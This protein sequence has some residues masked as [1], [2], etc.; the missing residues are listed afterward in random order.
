MDHTGIKPT[1]LVLSALYH[2]S[3]MIHI[4]CSSMSVV[5]QLKASFELE[6]FSWIVFWWKEW[7]KISSSCRMEKG[8]LSQDLKTPPMLDAIPWTS[9]KWVLVGFAFLVSQRGG[10]S[11]LIQC[12]MQEQSL[13]EAAEL[14]HHLLCGA[15]WHGKREGS[16]KSSCGAGSTPEVWLVGSKALAPAGAAAISFLPHALPLCN[17][18]WDM[19]NMK[20]FPSWTSKSPLSYPCAAIN[21]AKSP[22]EWAVIWA[23]QRGREEVK[24][25]LPWP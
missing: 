6:S 21:Q 8:Q 15:P 11:E 3:A 10:S 7:E 24:Q 14:R 16:L 25:E 9:F 18:K 12:S 13:W 22:G 19:P 4:G 20:S 1:A 17:S 5:F 23:K 2:S